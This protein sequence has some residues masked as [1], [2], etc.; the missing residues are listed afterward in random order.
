VIMTTEKDHRSLRKGVLSKK[1]VWSSEKIQL[2]G[3]VAPACFGKGGR[4]K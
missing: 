2:Q 3:A 1:D 4:K